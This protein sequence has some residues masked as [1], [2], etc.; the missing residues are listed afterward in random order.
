MCIAAIRTSIVGERSV[1]APISSKYNE[2]P[3]INS[4]NFRGTNYFWTKF[5]RHNYYKMGIG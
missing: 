5:Q 1:N 2:V 3:T 4:N